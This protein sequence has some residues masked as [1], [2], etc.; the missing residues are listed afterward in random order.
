MTSPIQVAIIGSKPAHTGMWIAEHTPWVQPIAQPKP[1][2]I[3]AVVGAPGPT[4][5]ESEPYLHTQGSA[6]VEWTVNHNKGFKPVLQILSVGGVV[7]EADISHITDN[8]TKVFFAAP[9][10]GYAV[11]R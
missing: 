7:V 4:G 2:Q 8:Q 5:P 11:A 10:S 1:L 9:Y 6:S 3:V